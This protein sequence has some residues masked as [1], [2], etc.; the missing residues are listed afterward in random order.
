MTI[1]TDRAASRYFINLKEGGGVIMFYCILQNIVLKSSFLSEY[2]VNL[3]DRRAGA[4]H[5]LHIVILVYNEIL[6]DFVK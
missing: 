3:S 1:Y 5:V 2:F 4:Y 6:H